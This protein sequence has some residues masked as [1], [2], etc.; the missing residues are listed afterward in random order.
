MYL[1]FD[2]KFFTCREAKIIELVSRCMNRQ[3]PFIDFIILKNNSIRTIRQQR[4]VHAEEN[5]FSYVET[6]A[7]TSNNLVSKQPYYY[8]NVIFFR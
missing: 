7:Q 8:P 3:L 4:R 2:Y 1:E 5:D 6:A